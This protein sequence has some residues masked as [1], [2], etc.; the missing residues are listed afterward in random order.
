[1]EL[2]VDRMN[3]K[4]FGLEKNENSFITEIIPTMTIGGGSK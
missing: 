2:L 1:V 3:S 4:W